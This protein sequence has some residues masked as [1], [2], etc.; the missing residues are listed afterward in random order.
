MQHQTG[1][2]LEKLHAP[3]MGAPKMLA[4]T[5]C[6]RRGAVTDKAE[7]ITC[8]VCAAKVVGK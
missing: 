6:G 3:K 5:A 1:R 4:L 7:N 2:F 8:K